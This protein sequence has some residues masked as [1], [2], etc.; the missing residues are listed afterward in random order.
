MEMFEKASVLSKSLEQFAEDLDISESKYLEA[1]KRYEAVG[2]WL[3]RD[4]SPLSIHA[5]EI[6]PQGSFALGTVIK[7]ITNKDEYDIDLVCFLAKLK[8][9]NTSQSALK[10][11]VG[12]RLKANDTYKR[13]LD[14]EGHRCWTLNYANEFHMDILPAIAD[15]VLRAQGGLLLDAILITDKQKIASGDSEWPKSNPRGY[16]KWFQSRQETVDDVPEYKIKTPLQRAIQ[17]LKRHRDIYCSRKKNDCKPISIIITTLAASLYKGQ[18]NVYSAIYDILFGITD[19]AI[20]QVDKFYI[21]NPANPGE[22][23]A[24]KWDKNPDLPRAFF[25][26]VNDARSVF[27]TPLIEKV[28]SMVFGKKLEESLGIKS[29]DMDSG[30]KYSNAPVYVKVN[31]SS[32]R[33]PWG[34]AC[35]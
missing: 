27:G 30:Q 19:N 11:M 8:K 28:D 29:R 2:E 21:P 25:E 15:D 35:V 33:R 20:K 9:A 17:I 12:D 1:K 23:F 22:N 3:G 6:Y 16:L 24:D 13:L 14:P 18:D 31:S 10:S 26:W 5:P 7:P 34:S 32:E 4:D